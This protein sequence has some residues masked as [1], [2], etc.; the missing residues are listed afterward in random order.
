MNAD[1]TQKTFY[2]Y[3]MARTLI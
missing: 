3:L 1:L 2:K